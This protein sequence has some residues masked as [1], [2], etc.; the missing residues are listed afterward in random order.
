MWLWFTKC[1]LLISI[2]APSR[3]RLLNIHAKVEELLISIHAPLRER[4]EMPSP[5]VSTLI[6]Q[7]TLPCGSDIYCLYLLQRQFA[8]Q[9]T[10]PCG[11]DPVKV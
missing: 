5:C 10:L 2:H 1:Y 7:S 4:P 6:F 9:S 11:S 3:E 8:F